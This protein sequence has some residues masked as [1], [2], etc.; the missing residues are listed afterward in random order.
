MLTLAKFNEVVEISYGDK[1]PNKLCEYVYDLSNT[2]NRFYHENKILVE[3]DSAKKIS[4]LNLLKLT[5]RTIET[6]LELLGMEVP[7]RM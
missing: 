2:F 1:T 7:E 3:E 5:E 4:W 6:V